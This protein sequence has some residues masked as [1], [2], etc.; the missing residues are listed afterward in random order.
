[1]W[2]IEA[3]AKH[4]VARLLRPGFTSIRVLLIESQLNT[5]TPLKNF[6][7]RPKKRI[8]MIGMIRVQLKKVA[9]MLQ[10]SEVF[11]RTVNFHPEHFFQEGR[12]SANLSNKQINPETIQTPTEFWRSPFAGNVSV[13]HRAPM[14]STRLVSG[15]HTGS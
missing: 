7:E 8:V 10:N 11:V 1:M 6:I 3:G 13:Q 5:T 14:G 9:P 2:T 12:R 15:R 4:R